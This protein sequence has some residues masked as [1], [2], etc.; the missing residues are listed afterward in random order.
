MG[1]DDLTSALLKAQG[2]QEFMGGGEATHTM[3][4]GTVMPGATHGQYQAM[5]MRHGGTAHGGAETGAVINDAELRRQLE[6]MMGSETGAVIND[7]EM[8]QMMQGGGSAL[9]QAQMQLMGQPQ[10]ASVGPAA[11]QDSNAFI[12]TAIED[13]MTRAAM[14]NDPD[15]SQQYQRMAEGA[16]LGSNAPMGEQAIALAQAGRGGDTAL[17]HLRQGEVVI[18][19]EAFEDPEFERAVQKRFGQLDLDPREHIVGTGIASLNPVTGLEEFGWFSDAGDKFAK[20]IGP[21]AEYAQHIPGPW[22]PYAALAAKASTVYDVAKGRKNPLALTTVVGP[23]AKGGSIRTNVGAINQAGVNAGGGFLKGLG[24]LA[25]QTG[26]A[27]MGGAGNLATNPWQTFTTA[28]P[29]L[30]NTASWDGQ[31]LTSP[32]GTPLANTQPPAGG[33]FTGGGADRV[34]SFGRVGDFFGGITDKFGLT[35]YGGGTAGALTGGNALAAAFGGGGFGGKDIAA[36][37]LAG[38]LGKL[39]YD[40]AKD[41]KGVAQTPLT[42]MNAA[43]RYNIEAEVARRMGKKA[44]NPTEFGLLPANTFPT[45]SGGRAPTIAQAALE[46]QKATG[47]RHG[48]AVRQYAEGGKVSTNDFIKMEGGIDGEGTETSD[49]IPAMLSDGEFV[50]TGQAVRGAGAF[51]LKKKKNGI[52]SL[53]PSGEGTREQGT[54]LMYQMMDLF[55]SFAGASS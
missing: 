48:G 12:E 26:T 32:A 29:T 14:T 45:L 3:P 27:I 40:E 44:P 22:Q 9:D 21:V 47:R 15:A 4:D 38:L 33:L 28:I 8:Q 41:S 25:S 20:I 43:G 30:L 10:E 31:P 55:K 24:S 46:Q 50:M 6:Q 42:T 34:G 5:G 11:A 51:T 18:P 52:I 17:A 7:A 1:N 36:L 53:E 49:D 23:G 2:I 16:V 19:P 13:L 35:N 54:Q 39:A 37:G